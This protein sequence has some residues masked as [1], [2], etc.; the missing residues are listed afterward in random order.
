MKIKFDIN[1]FYD[2]E[3]NEYYYVLTSKDVPGLVVQA[4][5]IDEAI[6][7]WKILAKE[8]LKEQHIKTDDVKQVDASLS[9][10]Y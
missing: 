7:E 10:I 2:D 8:L 5:S 9:L 6:K 4:F 1:Q 3:N